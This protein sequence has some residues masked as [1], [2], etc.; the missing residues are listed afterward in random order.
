MTPQIQRERKREKERERERER[1]RLL[2]P[3]ITKIMH[4]KIKKFNTRFAINTYNKGKANFNIGKG[5]SIQAV[6]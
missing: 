2:G 3:F 5:S 1:K 4:K 6:F